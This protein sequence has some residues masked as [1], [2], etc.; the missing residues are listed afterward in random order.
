VPNYVKLALESALSVFGIRSQY[1]GPRY[2]VLEYVGSVEIRAYGRRLAAE[3]TVTAPDEG[4]GRDEAFKILAAYIFGRN[5]TGGVASD[6]VQPAAA[7]DGAK[8]DPPGREIAM[9]TPVQSST[10]GAGRFVMRFFLPGDLTL[11][12]APKPLDARV[13][14]LELPEETLA[15]LSFGGRAPPDEVARR[16]RELAEALEPSA[17]RPAGE[18]VALF[19]D[20][21]FTLP[22]LRR[23]EVAV[24]VEPARRA[25]SA[26]SA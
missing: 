20:P 2:K 26:A 14:L 8:A 24:A 3:A 13:R 18:P 9:T 15:A 7:T 6:A 17:W 1:E 5:R 11:A 21:P 22:F 12:T 23:N 25:A 19:Y 4:A 10:T 16:R